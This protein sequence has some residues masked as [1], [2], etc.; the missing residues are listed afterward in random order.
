MTELLLLYDMLLLEAVTD[1]L[2][3]DKRFEG[4]PVLFG[5]P[6]SVQLFFIG[7]PPTFDF[8][9]FVSVSYIAQTI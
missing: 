1:F 6:S 7:D 8:L 4:E 3:Y 9:I 5:D 2:F